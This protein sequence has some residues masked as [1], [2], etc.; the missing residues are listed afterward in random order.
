M[1]P[2]V[3]CDP[4]P[5][6]D[7]AYP[8]RPVLPVVPATPA[9]S[10]ARAPTVAEFFRT[11]KPGSGRAVMLIEVDNE[12]PADVLAELIQVPGVREA[13]ALRLG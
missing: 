13:R 7:D 10:V 9:P 11:F 2:V 8:R 6:P 4:R 1:V 3:P 12:V 5:V